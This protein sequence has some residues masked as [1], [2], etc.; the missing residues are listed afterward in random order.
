MVLDKT[1]TLTQGK[2]QVTDIL[3]AEGL[4][5][6]ALLGLAACLEAPS[7]HPLGAAIVEEAS[8]RKLPQQ[9]VEGFE[10]VHGRGVRAVLGGHTCLAGS[11]AR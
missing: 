8:E 11:R 4:A 6:N 7:E 10:A 9:P 3:P 1:G 2:P 5:E